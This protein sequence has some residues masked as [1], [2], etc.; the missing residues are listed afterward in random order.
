VVVGGEIADV[1][2]AETVPLARRRLDAL[3]AQAGLPSPES[4]ES[5]QRTLALLAG[6]GAT[7]QLVGEEVWD[8]D[9]EGLS[10][11]LAPAGRSRWAR[12][13]AQVFKSRYRAAKREVRTLFHDG[14]PSGPD[15]QRRGSSGMSGDV[16]GSRQPTYR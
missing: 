13:N 15:A 1:L 8:A 12:M 11:A 14:K 4:I 5:W 6:V 10:D 3:L 2:A 9:L 7:L 16:L